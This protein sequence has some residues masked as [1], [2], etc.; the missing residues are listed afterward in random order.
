MDKLLEALAQKGVDASAMSGEQ[1]EKVA[2]AVGIDPID[3]L[4]RNVEVVD[5]TN[6][7]NETNRFV[8]T[9]GFVVG[10]KEDGT[11]QIVKGLFLRVDAL[12]Q[13]IADLQAAKA[14]LTK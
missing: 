2:K 8:K 6:K 11:A 13:A 7:R 9:P 12:D 4:P 14:G 5:Y 3:Y 1:I 10:R